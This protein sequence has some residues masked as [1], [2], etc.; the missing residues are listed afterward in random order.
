MAYEIVRPRISGK[1]LSREEQIEALDEAISRFKPV[2][3]AST[4]APA[5]ANKKKK[6]IN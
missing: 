6:T 5:D 4:M 2:G 3:G 1:P